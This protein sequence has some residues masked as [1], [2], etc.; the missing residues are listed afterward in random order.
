[1]GVITPSGEPLT[2]FRAFIDRDGDKLTD[3]MDAAHDMIGAGS[4]TWGPEPLKRV[5]KPYDPDH[6][7]GD[8]LK[9]KGLTLSASLPDDWRDRGVVPSLN[10]QFKAPLPVWSLI[11]RI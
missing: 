3:A 11:G 6:P 7:H 4:G 2:R 8:L 9:R 10:A 5:P 1:M